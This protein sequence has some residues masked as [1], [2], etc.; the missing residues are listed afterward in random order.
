MRTQRFLLPILCLVLSV[1]LSPASVARSQVLLNEYVSSNINGLLDEDGD[2]S[3]WIE[4]Y[5]DGPN[6]VNLDGFGLSDDPEEA[7]KWAFQEVVIPPHGHLLIFASGKDRHLGAAHWETVIDWGDVWK[8]LANH[9]PPP[10]DWREPEFDD[11]TWETGPTGIGYGDDDDATVIPPCISACLRK[12]FQVEDPNVVRLICLHVDYDDAFVAYLNGVEIARANISAPGYPAWNQPADQGREALIY[13][14]GLPDLYLGDGTA[15]LL[16]TGH[17]VL[18]IEVHN[19]APASSD[20]SLIPFLTL[21]MDEPPSGGG[22][23][24]AHFIRFLI[25]RLHTNFKIDAAGETL[26]LHDPQGSLLDSVATG[27]LYA[28]LSRGRA[29]DA[30]PVWHFFTEPT[31]E[32][33]NAAG[34]Y[35]EFADPPAF[36]VPGG[37]YPGTLVLQLSS[38]SPCAAIYYTTDGADPTV[39]S[40]PYTVPIAITQS[41]VIRARAF[42][43]A[44]LP[45]LVITHSYILDD[46]ASMA[47]VSLATDPYNLWD[48]EYGIYV[49]PNIW[50]NWERP[51]HV[52]LFESDATLGFRLDAGVKIHGGS[53]RTLPQKSLRLLARAGYGYPLIEYPVFDEKPITAFKRLVLRNSG[54]DWCSSMLRDALMHRI[55]AHTDLD[56]QAYRPCRV[57]LNGAYWGIHNIREKIGQYYLAE[58]HG[59]DPDEVDLLEFNGVVIEGSAEHYLA[60]L[61][62]IQTHGLSDSTHFAY[63]QTQMD[64]A[65]FATYCIFQIFYA[66]TDW[67]GNNN[68]YWR[69]QTANDRWRWI[70]LDTDF[71]LGLESGYW[72]NTLA[73]ALEPDGPQWPNPPWSTF[74]LRSLMENDT[75]RH[76]FINCYADH[77]NSSFLPTRTTAL[78]QGIAALIEDEIPRHMERWNRPVWHWQNAMNVIYTFLA[79]RSQH[80]RTHIIDEFRLPGTF[81]LSLDIVPHGGGGIALTAISVDSTWSG[82]YFRDVPVPLSA[83]PAP[84]YTFLG[85]SDPQLPQQPTVLI[86]PSGDYS[87]A[88][89]FEEGSVP[90]DTQIVIN[91]INYHSAASF[92]PGDWVE[93]Y[94]NSSGPVDLGNW[95]FKDE[96]DGHIFTIP[97]GTVLQAG[98]YVVLCRSV[99][100]FSALFPEVSPV[101]GDLDFG[102]SGGGELLRLFDPTGEPHDY[103]EYDDEPP[104]PTEPDGHG[105]TLE[106]IDPNLA[107]TLPASWAA[108]LDHGTPGALNSASSTA[109]IP[110][111]P[112]SPEG[113]LYVLGLQRPCPNPLTRGTQICFTLDQDRHTR[114]VAYD[115]SGRRVLVLIAGRFQRGIHRVLW[116]GRDDAGH[117]LSPGIYLLQMQADAFRTSRKILVLP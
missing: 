52:E 103:V 110:A 90:P 83:I 96:E 46:P 7:F 89:L 34:G 63:I 106:L 111:R 57:Y 11:S 16:Q 70:L 109:S 82:T 58:N 32:E 38:P 29:P 71:G 77:L 88:A 54:N 42:E 105:P 112:D 67:P 95:V 4:L 31:P 50:E 5:N 92:D 114:L 91:E 44:H 18:A 48:E 23:G 74:L 64:T 62:Y 6:D 10:A 13:Q 101:L 28:D 59:V 78:A 99:A 45:S 100:D 65:N 8:Y 87:V 39:Q 3:D 81:S 47:A 37:F 108:S 12:A 9:S 104:W 98:G 36:S 116:T 115:V 55:A 102:F 17:N 80:A 60:M 79:M 2:S 86:S 22:V 93:L 73:F 107:N 97:G 76:A 33:P 51:I 43:D 69:P 19:V 20:M 66:N 75:F 26:S 113:R 94:N 61:E 1:A 85:W 27:Q 15:S 30:G 117:R 41:C 40:I 49:E 53:S 24:V 84:G 35:P 56:R 21:G 68:K 14:G 72:H 25:P